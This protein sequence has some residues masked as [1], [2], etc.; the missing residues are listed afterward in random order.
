MVM[1]EQLWDV[2]ILGEALAHRGASAELMTELIKAHFQSQKHTHLTVWCAVCLYGSLDSTIYPHASVNS[3]A[4]CYLTQVQS[5][6]VEWSQDLHQL[7]SIMDTLEEEDRLLDQAYSS[8]THQSRGSN[9][10]QS[11]STT[12][13]G[14]DLRELTA[15]VNLQTEIAL[16]A[17]S[18]APQ[19]GMELLE[20]IANLSKQMVGEAKEDVE[21]FNRANKSVGAQGT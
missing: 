16:S 19:E 14:R 12:T 4:T 13:G 8:P 10:T 6:L 7:K 15:H 9:G 1:L 21:L 3:A 11:N 17:T 5:H 2:G 20:G 18:Q